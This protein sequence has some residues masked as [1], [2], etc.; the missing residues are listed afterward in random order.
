LLGTVR[1]ASGAGSG[2]RRIRVMTSCPRC[3]R[4]LAA[5]RPRCV[6]CGAEAPPTAAEAPPAAPPEPTRR[7]LVIAQTA[8]AD[9]EA[10]ARALGLAAADAAHRVRRGGWQLLR[11]AE[12]AAA[13]E[14]V[15]RLGEAGVVAVLVPEAEV[16]LSARPVVAQGGEWTG[17]DLSLRTTEG[18]M[19]VEAAHLV[20]AVQGPIA[21][22]YQTSPEVKRTRTATLESGYRFH[23][24]RKGAARPVELD[25]GAFD[26]G[27]RA[28][29]ASSLL[30]LS[31]WVQELTRGV[32]VDDAFRRLPPELGVAELAAAGPLAAADALGARAAVRGEAALVL[33]NLR[34]FRFY[35]AWR[36]A[37]EPRGGS[38]GT[39]ESPPPE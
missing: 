25:P 35:S 9:P 1:L 17:R 39:G 38:G 24:H 16:R 23:L 12:P 15:A 20:L 26:F 3:G 6:Y 29:R 31:A 33:D 10:L 22:E 21:R 30:Q 13:R 19:R 8:D 37:V 5:R 32:P 27:S 2:A 34:Q 14:Q 28:S 11:I 36:A 18:P 4:P 7:L